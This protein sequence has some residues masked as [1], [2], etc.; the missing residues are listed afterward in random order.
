MIKPINISTNPVLYQNRSAKETG[1]NI[2]TPGVELSNYKTGQ[3][4]LVRNNISFYSQ[5]FI[6]KITPCCTLILT[7]EPCNPTVQINMPCDKKFKIKQG[8]FLIY[9]MA[10]N[11][12]IYE[13]NQKKWRSN[14]IL[15]VL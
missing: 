4:I 13:Q 7:D 8:L 12:Q 14:N 2:T 15:S 3:A 10:L 9:S 1:V 5:P 6:K 11:D